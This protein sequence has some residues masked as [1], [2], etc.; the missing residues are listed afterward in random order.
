MRWSLRG[1]VDDISPIR[2]TDRTRRVSWRGRCQACQLVSGIAA[3][4]Q[5]TDNNNIYIGDQ[6]ITSLSAYLRK[7]CFKW[8]RTELA[9]CPTIDIG[10]CYTATCYPTPGLRVTICLKLLTDCGGRPRCAVLMSWLLLHN[11]FPGFRYLNYSAQQ[12]QS[13]SGGTL[14]TIKKT[15][16]NKK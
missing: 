4:S 16:K 14:R 2:E 3:G 7:W 1:A 11:T 9:S 13:G 5:H 6:Q 8:H 15:K 12:E 10:G